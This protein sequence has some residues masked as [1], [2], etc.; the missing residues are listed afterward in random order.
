MTIILFG[1]V[2]ALLWVCGAVLAITPHKGCLPQL[3]RWTAVILSVIVPLYLMR[4]EKPSLIS[5]LPL[6]ASAVVLSFAVTIATAGWRSL[7]SARQPDTDDEVRQ[8]VDLSLFNP[9]ESSSGKSSS[10]SSR[11][12]SDTMDT[13]LIIIVLV[14]FGALFWVGLQ[15]ALLVIRLL[16]RPAGLGRLAGAVVT[17]ALT[18]A[19]TGGTMVIMSTVAAAPNAQAVALSDQPLSAS[20]SIPPTPT[21]EIPLLPDLYPAHLRTDLNAAWDAVEKPA[22]WLGWQMRVTPPFPEVWPPTVSSSWVVYVYATAQEK[23]LADGVRVANAWALLRLSEGGKSGTLE[24]LSD[25]L[26][27]AGIQ[28]V[29]PLSPVQR[30]VLNVRDQVIEIMLALEAFPTE[31]QAAAA[32]LYYRAWLQTNGAVLEAMPANEAQSAFIEWAQTE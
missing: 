16:P 9:F 5:V 6:A 26:E 7:F 31:A 14:V 22:T 8:R 1:S 21:V 27:P 2:L 28:G 17:L 30:A 3:A 12:S 18:L 25:A 4:P 13:L 24:T 29:F 10:R 19:A 20:T 11:S 23:E 32:Q 15:I